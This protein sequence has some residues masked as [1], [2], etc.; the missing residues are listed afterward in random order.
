MGGGDRKEVKIE[1]WN[2]RIKRRGEDGWK[3][4]GGK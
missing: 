4:E 2:E 3:D 1:K